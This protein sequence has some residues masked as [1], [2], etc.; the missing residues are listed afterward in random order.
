MIF[1]PNKIKPILLYTQ[2]SQNSPASTLISPIY[3]RAKFLL[4]KITVL[5]ILNLTKKLTLLLSVQLLFNT[6]VPYLETS[7][8]HKN[9][10]IFA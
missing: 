6:L 4:F 9:S 10:K 2:M 8:N 7:V 1:I 5:K 3:K